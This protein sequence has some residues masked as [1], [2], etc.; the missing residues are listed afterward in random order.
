M[1]QRIVG[2]E[3]LDSLP[4]DDPRAK[5]SR[6]DLRR[7]HRVMGTCGIVR[8]ALENMLSTQHRP[9]SLRVL[10]LGAGDGTLMLEVARSFSPRWSPVELTL[11][12][13]QPLTSR[14]TVDGF[15][16]VLWTAVP[17]TVDIFDWAQTVST[18][19]AQRGPH[20]DLIVANLFLHHFSDAQLAALMAAISTRT[21][22]FFACEPRRS[23]LALMGS[24]LVG[25][26]GSNAITRVDAVLS[27]R[28]GFCNRELTQLWPNLR[29][30]W[31]VTE[32]SVGLFSHC[33]RV[34]RKGRRI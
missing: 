16:E 27:V 18:L 1:Q 2:E 25:L 13:R 15:A 8:R 30:D 4:A 22:L 29:D 12:D 26:I 11:L 10:E 24:H 14:A 9:S 19:D 33:L 7:I 20:W 3:M 6:S 34:E 17:L 31:Q 23:R 21:P 32:Y 28:A 5:R